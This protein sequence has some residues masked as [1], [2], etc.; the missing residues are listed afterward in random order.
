MKKTS[1][2][3]FLPCLLLAYRIVLQVCCQFDFRRLPG[4]GHFCPWMVPPV[5]IEDHNV[6]ERFES[7]C[8]VICKL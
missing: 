5:E 8:F 4:G 3:V 1:K 2:S 7:S 6:A